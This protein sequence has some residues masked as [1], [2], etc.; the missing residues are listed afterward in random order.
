MAIEK[1]IVVKLYCSDSIE[2]KPGSSSNL[3]LPDSPSPQYLVLSSF[4]TF[5]TF[6]P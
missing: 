2:L 6:S 1:Y 4:D 5:F 3:F